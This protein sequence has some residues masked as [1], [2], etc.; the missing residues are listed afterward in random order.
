MGIH[1]MELSVLL[2]LVFISASAFGELFSITQGASMILGPQPTVLST[3]SSLECAVQCM[4]NNDCSAFLFQGNTY[5]CYLLGM[6][7]TSSTS[8]E[9][10]SN[11]TTGTLF[12][13]SKYH[14]S[15]FQ[16]QNQS[17]QFINSAQDII[18]D[19]AGDCALA[20]GRTESCTSFSVTPVETS[21]KKGMLCRIPPPADTYWK[22][23]N[24]T[25]L[26]F[27]PPLPY[28]SEVQLVT[29]GNFYKVTYAVDELLITAD[30]IKKCEFFGG[31]LAPMYP[32][33]RAA[34]IEAM[35]VK[36]FPDSLINGWWTSAVG[37]GTA[38][39]KVFIPAYQPA[40]EEIPAGFSQAE[41]GRYYKIVTSAS[42][43]SQRDSLLE[44]QA[45]GGTS[46]ALPYPQKRAEKI[47]K[48]MQAVGVTSAWTIG[49]GTAAGTL[50][51]EYS[52]ELKLMPNANDRNQAWS[53]S[54][55]IPNPVT[56]SHCITLN[57]D[58]NTGAPFW[59][60][61]DCSST[62]V[63]SYVC[64]ASPPYFQIPSTKRWF[65]M[66]LHPTG[67]PTGKM[68]A[69]W[70]C[71]RDGGTLAP[72]YGPTGLPTLT[73]ALSMVIE[74]TD[75]FVYA[76]GN[77]LLNGSW[78]MCG[79]TVQPSLKDSQRDLQFWFPGE[80]S[81]EAGSN[82][83]ALKYSTQLGTYAWDDA[84]VYQIGFVCGLP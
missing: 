67:N 66:S 75:L 46:L 61:M 34:A 74:K 4:L 38:D 16:K 36:A 52:G 49:K 50:V 78:S 11:S 23:N 35:H 60:A 18:V 22:E 43:V 55:S 5:E 30:L 31:A 2:F 82:F 72:T 21:Q 40:A 69:E 80:P 29:D 26:Y 24:E 3:G 81:G 25:T 14:L 57:R 45:L 20:C 47:A 17:G 32:R 7:P 19:S 53:T 77:N 73:N 65:R 8:K 59:N 54:S 68:S 37:F 64:E 41:D 70:F 27:E 58:T 15:G 33:K 9:N 39:G 79:G 1:N 84:A 12:M 56:A 76:C 62:V 28:L 13:S 83:L 6:L 48:L 10:Y 44:C 42:G 51:V 63:K 71:Q